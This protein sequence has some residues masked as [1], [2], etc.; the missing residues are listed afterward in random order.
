M[1]SYSLLNNKKQKTKTRKQ[2]QQKG[3]CL[4]SL[5][6]CPANTELSPPGGWAN[7]FALFRPSTDWKDPTLPPPMLDRVI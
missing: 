4:L 2:Q 7:I 1:L 5:P 6:M 3:H